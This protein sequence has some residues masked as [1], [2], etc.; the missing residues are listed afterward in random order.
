M[1]LRSMQIA[2]EQTCGGYR[3]RVGVLW[4]TTDTVEAGANAVPTKATNVLF[5]GRLFD[6][7]RLLSAVALVNEMRFWLHAWVRGSSSRCPEAN[8][9]PG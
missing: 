9:Q 2:P 3:A 8:N 5:R 4:T 7:Y 6:P 1:T